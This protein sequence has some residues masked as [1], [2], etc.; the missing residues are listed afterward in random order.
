MARLIINNDTI[1]FTEEGEKIT[2]R[3]ARLVVDDEIIFIVKYLHPGFKNN[4]MYR[5]KRVFSE[6][7]SS[8][9]WVNYPANDNSNFSQLLGEEIE[10][11]PHLFILS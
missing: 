11:M 8:Y 5:I 7:N 10:K 1:H 9:H 4:E 2:G 6:V 3:I